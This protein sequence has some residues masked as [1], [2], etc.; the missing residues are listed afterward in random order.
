MRRTAVA[1]ACTVAAI[2]AAP[3]GATREC[4]GFPVCVRVVGPWVLTGAHEVEFQLA[5]PRKFVVA[6]LDAELSVRGIAVGFRGLL[7]T[8]VNPGIT[9]SSSVVFLGRL[10]HGEAQAPS[11]RPHIGCIPGSG[12]GKRFPTEVHAVTPTLPVMTQIDVLAGNHGYVARC[13]AR[14]RLVGAT[15][16]IAFY[17]KAPPSPGLAATVRVEQ[18][19]HNGRVYVTVHGAPEIR[20]VSAV[21]QL[22][23][24]CA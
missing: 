21:V 16:A 4:T 9:T 7:G 10:V 13:P 6:G 18:A 2:A 12:A 14:E 23:L 17:T 3:A 19:I 11:F 1:L 15:H 20:G 22:D 24:L 5:C 8:P